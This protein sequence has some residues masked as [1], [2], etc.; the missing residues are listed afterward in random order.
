MTSACTCR[1]LNDVT[2]N[3]IHSKI[4][5]YADGTVIFCESKHLEKIENNLNAD[6]KNLVQG[7]STC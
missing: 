5:I 1:L 4:V 7:K 6:L 2:K 3:L